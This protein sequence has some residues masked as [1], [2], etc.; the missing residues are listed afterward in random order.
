M[1][2]ESFFSI[3]APNP[4]TL[5]VSLLSMTLSMPAKAPPQMKRMFDVSIWIIS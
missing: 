2:L 1:S 5:F 4:M 3:S